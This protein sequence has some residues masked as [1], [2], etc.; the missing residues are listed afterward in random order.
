M[1]TGTRRSGI[2]GRLHRGGSWPGLF[3][4]VALG[5]LPLLVAL[6]HE[7]HSYQDPVCNMQVDPERSAGEAEYAGRTF[8]F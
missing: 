8:F 7:G 1:G 6:G 4:A 3:L 5:G 2:R